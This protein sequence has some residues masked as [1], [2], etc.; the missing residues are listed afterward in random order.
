[1]PT[2]EEISARPLE[3]EAAAARR[4]LARVGR[5]ALPPVPGVR[6]EAERDPRRA[7]RRRSRE[8]EPGVL[9]GPR[10]EGRPDVRD[11]RDQ[12]PRALLR[13]PR[14]RR[15]ATRTGRSARSSSA[16]SARS[17][18][19]ASDLRATGDRRPRLGVD[20]VRLGR[21]ARSS[22]TSA[23]RRTRSPS[24]TR[25]R[26]SRSTSTSTRTSSTTR[27]IAPRTS[28]RSSRISTGASSTAGSRRTPS[29][30]E[31]RAVRPAAA[32][33]RLR[34]CRRR[35]DRRRR[36][37]RSARSRSGTCSPRLVRGEDVRRHGSGN[38]GASNVW[39]VYGRSL[40]I[41]VALLDV[42]KGFVPALVGLLVGGDWVGVL[43]GAAAMLGHAR[44]VFLGFRRAGR[45]SRR[46][47]A[48]RSRSRRSR[49]LLPGRLARRL[50]ALAVRL[51]SRRCR[52]RSALPVLASRLREPWPIVGF[53]AVAA[54]GVILLH[55][56][57]IRR[58][59]AGTEPRFSRTRRRLTAPGGA[60]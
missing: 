58:L 38:I 5:G 56:H 9:G 42:A 15:A 31:E 36:L 30:P 25:R 1:M 7:R 10:A 4:H 48:S 34:K 37:P 6:R 53:A 2:F 23:T 32:G 45:W 52:P 19:G 46:R 60:R 22:T 3:P 43:A 54:L 29:P 27:P 47:G 49:R 33:R 39:R 51:A 40:G 13:A 11:R 18:H 50:R 14:R 17:R 21:A 12:E 59:L 41:P 26:S 44:P 16:T 28:T 24:G 55:R 20:G 57:N 35:A 8:G